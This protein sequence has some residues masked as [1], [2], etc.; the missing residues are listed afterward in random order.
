VIFILIYGAF[1]QPMVLSDRQYYNVVLCIGKLLEICVLIILCTQ[2]FISIL[3][4]INIPKNFAFITLFAQSIFL[5]SLVI[6]ALFF[7]D[8][9]AGL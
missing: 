2:F 5:I 6:G 8:L 7:S 4:C 3:V 1:I 9:T